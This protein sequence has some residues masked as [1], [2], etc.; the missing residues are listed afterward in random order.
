MNRIVRA[1]QALVILLAVVFILIPLYLC[2]LP[3]SA[4]FAHKRSYRRRHAS[5]AV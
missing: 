2:S 1:L 4:Y 3:F 5:S